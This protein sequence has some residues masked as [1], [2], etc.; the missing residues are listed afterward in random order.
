MDKG[1]FFAFEGIDGSGKSTQIHLL[2]DKL[3][4]RGYR[5]HETREPTDGP[6][7]S[8][9]HQL[10]TGRLKADPRVISS[11][12]AA[13]R[14]DHLTNPIN[15]LETEI[16]RGVTILSDRYYFSSYAYN[17]LEMDMDWVIEINR[18]S[19]ELLPGWQVLSQQETEGLFL[20]AKEK[21]A[22]VTAEQT[23][24]MR[25]WMHT[26]DATMFISPDRKA[27][28]I[29][30]CRTM[31]NEL[32]D[33]YVTNLRNRYVQQVEK[34]YKHI[35]A[36]CKV[37]TTLTQT[38][39]RLSGVRCDNL[40]PSSWLLKMEK[41]NSH[42]FFTYKGKNLYT[43]VISDAA[44]QNNAEVHSSLFDSLTLA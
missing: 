12:F 34:K 41:S 39:N 13:D 29:I 19:A 17:G 33:A 42:V 30:S 11:L 20:H 28:I 43:I 9:V 25:E 38:G 5:C 14:L 23:A 16:K 21:N 26:G 1:L 18:C 10:M 40:H 6:V 15:G 24:L 4:Q 32:T 22:A 44:Q 36:G 37:D 8:I 7:G 35:D 31:E 27:S 3:Q 2:K